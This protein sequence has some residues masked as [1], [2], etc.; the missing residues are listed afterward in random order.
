M[1]L[2]FATKIDVSPYI[3]VGGAAPLNVT[4][5]TATTYDDSKKV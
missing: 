1:Y 4:P 5:Y 3:R 2:D